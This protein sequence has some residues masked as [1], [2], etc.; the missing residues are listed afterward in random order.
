MTPQAVQAIYTPSAIPEYQGNPFIECLPPLRTEDEFISYAARIPQ[1]NEAERGL[2]TE[3]R[4]HFLKRL[5]TIRL[6][7]AQMLSVHEFLEVELRAG[8]KS[9][10]P[11][12]T[13]A[14]QAMYAQGL[15][16]S[17]SICDSPACLLITGLSGTG[18]TTVI[19]TP[20][21]LYPVA[22]IHEGVTP[23]ISRQVQLVWLRVT[24]PINAGVRGLC[25]GILQSI[26]QAT[27]TTYLPEWLKSRCSTDELLQTI[28]TTI[29]NLQIGLLVL[30]E[31]QHLRSATY[32]DQ[33]SLLN[34]LVNL[35]AA[36]TPLVLI[37]TYAIQ[38]ILE[39]QLRNARRAS[40]V[41]MVQMPRFERESEPWSVLLASLW[42]CQWVRNPG[43]L[44]SEIEEALYDCS[45]GIWDTVVKVFYAA[46]RY[47]VNSG[48]ETVNAKA[49]RA[50]YGHEFIVL[51]KAH[52]LLRSGRLRDDDPQF[53]DLLGEGVR[54]LTGG[55]ACLAQATGDRRTTG[56]LN[57]STSIKKDKLKVTDRESQIP[58]GAHPIVRQDLRC[59][60]RDDPRTHLIELKL[61]DEGMGS[62]PLH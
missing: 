61:V 49:I 13:S 53:D 20:L 9:K 34:F 19:E 17:H 8:Y 2:P 32:K 57:A 47:A 50:V 43:P 24:C 3:T 10:D 62:I 54:D 33:M 21:Q 48:S 1:V 11:R 37:G 5:G 25:L 44:T 46:Q 42:S 39:K 56:D 38:G 6:P 41:G 45:L 27:G 26:D 14:R 60:D 51:H 18:K 28:Y 35:N 59:A 55:K 16:P 31:M 29:R 23:G 58:V 12:L 22:V 7:T 40:G 52:K 15:P 36:G 30:D 4:L